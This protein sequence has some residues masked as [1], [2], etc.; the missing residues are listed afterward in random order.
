MLC[1]M[2]RWE[3]A[4]LKGPHSTAVSL[5]LSVRTEKGRQGLCK[6]PGQRVRPRTAGMVGEVAGKIWFSKQDKFRQLYGVDD[7]SA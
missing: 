1:W 3:E 4:S 2:F 7:C 6:S 5:L